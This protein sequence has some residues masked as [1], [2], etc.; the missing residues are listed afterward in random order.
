MKYQLEM[1]CFPKRAVTF[2]QDDTINDTIKKLN[3]L[4][5]RGVQ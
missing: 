4:K 3:K 1:K 2:L 5:E